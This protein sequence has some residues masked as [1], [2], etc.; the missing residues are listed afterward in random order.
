MINKKILELSYDSIY[1]ITEATLS[2]YK[3]YWD[4]EGDP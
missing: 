2:D 3:L 1:D 4:P